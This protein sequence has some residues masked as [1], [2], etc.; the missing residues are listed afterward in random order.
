MAKTLKRQR[1]SRI[2]S[3]YFCSFAGNKLPEIYPRCVN[4]VNIYSVCI[5]EHFKSN[6]NVTNKQIANLEQVA[7]NIFFVNSSP[8]RQSLTDKGFATSPGSVD[9]FSLN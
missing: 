5:S 9:S 2:A 4:S 1:K 8:L 6:F 7:L 3:I